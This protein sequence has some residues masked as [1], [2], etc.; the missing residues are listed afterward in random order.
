MKPNHKTDQTAAGSE[1]PVE[2]KPA[3]GAQE[4]KAEPSPEQ[5]IA[6]LRQE[7]AEA[8]DK[9]L[10]AVAEFENTRRR[11]QRE[12]E[13]FAKYAAES[14]V[15]ELLP[16]IDGLSQALVA[17]DK[18]SDAK[19]I[20]TGVHMIYRQLLGLLEQNGVKRIPTVGEKFD[21]HVHEAVGDIPAE[22]KNED[23]HILEEVQAGYRMHGKTI[24]SA[25]V[26][27][28]KL[29]ENIQHENEEAK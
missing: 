25:L 11:M 2:S 14:V 21:P 28:G 4:P 6:Q 26:K 8:N 20:I 12:K 23:G 29:P 10:R 17:V 22:N 27:V 19:A 24:R 18:Q 7:L 16:I 5:T 1:A 15:R 9:Y 13:E 3:E